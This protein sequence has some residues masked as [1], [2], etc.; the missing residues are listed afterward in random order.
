M[1]LSIKNT[2]CSAILNTETETSN[3][4]LYVWLQTGYLRSTADMD[5]INH[6]TLPSQRAG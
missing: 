4:S 3:H 1:S 2:C 6:V 5:T